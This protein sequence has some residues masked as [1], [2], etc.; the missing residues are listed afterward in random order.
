MNLT[1]I[2]FMT[3]P[4]LPWQRKWF[5]KTSISPKEVLRVLLLLVWGTGLKI[6]GKPLEISGKNENDL[7]LA[8][9]SPPPSRQVNLF[10]SNVQRKFYH[11]KVKVATNFPQLVLAWKHK[12]L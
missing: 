4:D 10:L 7:Y 6:V 3:A 9:S 8:N 5:V 11:K 1:E 2:S 12:D